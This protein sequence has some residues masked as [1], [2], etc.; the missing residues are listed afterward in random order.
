M[1]PIDE[2]SGTEKAA[3]LIVSLGSDTAAEIY[4]CLDDASLRRISL[5]VAKI[6]GLSVSD[7]E[8]LM[9]EFLIELRRSKRTVKGGEDVAKRLLI[10]AFGIE[11]AHELMRKVSIVHLEEG[12]EYFKDADPEILGTLLL[13]EH[14]QTIAVTLAHIPSAK[15][16]HILKMLPADAAKD[17]V[18]RVARM[19]GSAPDA[20]IEI[21]KVLRKKY[22]DFAK[23]RG[24]ELE[25]SGMNTLIEIMKRVNGD[26]E[27][28]IMDGLDSSVPDISHAIRT[29]IFS[30]DDVLNLSNREMRLFIDEIRNDQLIAKA[31]KGAGDELRYKFMRNMSQNRSKELL[32]EMEIMGAVRLTEIQECRDYIVAI[33]RRLDAQGKIVIRK[34]DED[35]VE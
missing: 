5:E 15:S 1:K 17:V 2:M 28:R 9:G 16:A 3:A 23:T 31:L 29:R 14:P 7:R 6:E 34:E 12:F 22:D 30:F 10:D 32:T 27:R 35:F 20:V 13:K 21:A 8:E 26:A 19:K 33:M 4:K 18:M 25:I 24:G 11:K